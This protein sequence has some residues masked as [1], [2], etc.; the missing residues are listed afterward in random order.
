MTMRMAGCAQ[1]DAIRRAPK[2]VEAMRGIRSTLSEIRG[3]L[4]GFAKPTGVFLALSRFCKVWAGEM[5]WSR[6]LC[7]WGRR[8]LCVICSAQNV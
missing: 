7:L 1:V 2:L 3:F 4:F 8:P 6:C 5:C